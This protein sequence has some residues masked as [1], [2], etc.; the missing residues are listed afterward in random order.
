M[1]VELQINNSVSP[2]AQFVCW[3]PSR[4]RIRV[5]N[6]AGATTPSV[7]VGITAAVLLVV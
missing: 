2:G 7:S 4:C 5:S 1:N 6:P 3:A